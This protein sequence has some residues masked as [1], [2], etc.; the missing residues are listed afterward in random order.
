MWT[1]L[2]AGRIDLCRS[3]GLGNL[4]PAF[5]ERHSIVLGAWRGAGYWLWKPYVIRDA[6]DWAGD[7]D[8]IIYCD[9]GLI[10]TGDVDPIVR[11]CRD[12]TPGVLGFAL[13]GFQEQFWTKRD[14][15][16]LME[17]DATV[18]RESPQIE[19]GLCIFINNDFARAFVDQWLHYAQ[20]PRILTDMPN[21]CGQDNLP[22]FRHHRHDQSIFSLLNKKHDLWGASHGLMQG[23]ILSAVRVDVQS[24]LD[25][26]RP[27]ARSKHMVRW[28]RPVSL[29][30][31]RR[32]QS[33]VD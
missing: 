16:V 20:D 32:P 28:L 21:Q 6:L 8:A 24:P 15:F 2:T 13:S 25:W 9:S 12:V 22:G 7:G 1:G 26:L 4:D 23:Q 18:F 30:R 10:F 29:A 33:S 27:L 19:S 17:C 14:A 31:W 5:R 11:I 3:Y